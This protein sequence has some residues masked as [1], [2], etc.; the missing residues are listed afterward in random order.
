MKNILRTF[1][2]SALAVIIIASNWPV[3]Y[4]KQEEYQQ[5]VFGSQATLVIRYQYETWAPVSIYLYHKASGQV[6]EE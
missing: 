5:R 4:A 1:W 3:W 6:V 2:T